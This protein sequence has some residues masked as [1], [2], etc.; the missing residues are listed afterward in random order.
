[1]QD[2]NL[3]SLNAL[4]VFL[5]A[6]RSLSLTQAAAQLGVTPGAVSHQIRTLENTLGVALFHRSNNAISLTDE[7]AAL[8][9]EAAPGLAVLSGA[10][11]N[12]SRSAQ[13]LTVQAPTTFATRWLIPRLEGFRKKA[14]GAVIRLDTQEPRPG[15]GPLCDV[16][17][18]YYRQDD[19]PEGAEILLEDRCQPYL[20]PR[21]LESTPDPVDLS[22]IP[23]LQCTQ[24]NWDWRMWLEESETLKTHLR[25]AGYFDID[26]AALRAAVAGLGMV[27]APDFIIR[28]DIAG[29]RLCAVPGQ[30]SRILGYYAVER[31]A[32]ETGLRESFVR[33]L[34][35][36]AGQ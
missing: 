17:L 34:H 13:E 25:F 6:A 11:A 1:M 15:A 30:P 36:E 23:A 27:L 22:T 5:L 31:G 26:D 12:V 32:R 18:S 29:G 21:L 14:P 16:T 19:L 20:S 33:W 4:R 24:G 10:L 9:R 28:D 7:G 3:F 35:R 2:P 8:A